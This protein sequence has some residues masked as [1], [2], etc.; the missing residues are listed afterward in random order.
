MT[1]SSSDLYHINIIKDHHTDWTTSTEEVAA[2]VI[3]NG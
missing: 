2:L 3:D 1:C